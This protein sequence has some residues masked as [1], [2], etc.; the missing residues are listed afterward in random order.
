MSYFAELDENN[1]VIRILVGDDNMPNDGKD[2][3]ES[4]L[5]GIWIETKYSLNFRNKFAEVGDTYLLDYDVFISPQIFKS[6]VLNTDTFIWESPTPY[7]NDSGIY[8]WN[9]ETISWIPAE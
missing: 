4:T 1:L 6:W 5:G 9:E 3:F 8:E 7:P 2:W